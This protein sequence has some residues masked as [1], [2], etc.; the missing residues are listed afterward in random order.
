M[1]SEGARW[2]I[3]AWLAW[4]ALGW[5]PSIVLGEDRPPPGRQQREPDSPEIEEPD[6]ASPEAPAEAIPAPVVRTNEEFRIIE[7]AREPLGF[8]GTSW[9]PNSTDTVAR[10]SVAL[11]DRWR[12]GW[13]DWDR[14]GRRAPGD[15]TLMNNEGGDSPYTRGSVLNPYDRNVLKGDYPIIGEDIFIN[16]FAV[17]DTLLLGRRLPTPSGAS[18][19][20]SGA[21]EF[22]GDGDQFF[23][24]QTLL[25]GADIFQGYSSFRPVDWLIRV[26]GAFNFNHLNVEEDNVVNIDTR[27]GN[28][29][30]D[31]HFSLQEAFFELHLGDTS[32]YFDV[33]AVRAG[34]QLFVSDFRG[35]IYNDI[36]DGVRLLGNAQSNRIQ[37]NIAFFNQVNKDTN[38]ELNELEWREQY[39]TIANLYIQDFIWE[40]YT[41]QFSFHWNHDESDQSFDENGFLVRPSLI[42]S[43]TPQTLD[44]MY[45]GWA[46]DGHIGRL[47]V[48]H[49]LYYAFGRDEDNPLAGRDVDISAFLAAIELSV[50]ID[51]F[52]PKVSFL[53]ASG[54]SDPTDGTAGGFDGIFENPFFAGGP[55]SFYQSQPLRLF[56]VNLVSARTFYNDLAGAKAEGQANFVNPGVIILNTGFDAELT[57]KLRTSFNVSSLWF[58]ETETLDLFLNQRDIDRHIGVEANLLFQYRP[59]LNNNVILTLGGSVFAPGD[60]FEQVFEK[61][62]TLWQAFLGVTLSY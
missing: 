33:A 57:P 62:D 2:L 31:D 21:F 48:N 40:G 25:F 23:A 18:A 27:F 13:T 6:Q 4:A 49:A 44:A 46:S 43:V 30:D 34:R 55:S 47:N 8:E 29:R 3:A 37:Y 42:G 26:S 17:S 36:G 22:F 1:R 53:Y 32:P 19:D 20:D 41:T 51:W 54:D 9:V 15:E 39:V 38:S 14:Y 59:L 11:P 12:L 50:D 56:G 60:G 24:S 16:A 5:W 35:F 52:R 28:E 58:S 45:L 61:D 10:S 7:R